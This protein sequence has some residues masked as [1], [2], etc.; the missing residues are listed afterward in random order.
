MI[1]KNVPGYH[2][3]ASNTTVVDLVRLIT[4]N[5][6]L[7]TLFVLISLLAV[8]APAGRATAEEF[9][10][11]GAC[12]LLTVDHPHSSACD[13]EI[14]ANPLPDLIRPVAYVEDRD[15]EAIPR[16]ILL[17]NDPLPYPVAWQNHAWY[18]SD[19]PGVYPEND[20]TEARRIGRE[21]MYFI[22]QSVV[23]GG[24]VWHLIGPDRWMRAAFVSVL[25]IPARPAGVTGRWVAL[26]LRQQTLVAL[27]DD[28]PVF[29]TLISSGYY[30]QTTLGLYQVYARTLSMTMKGP[31]G[32]N[33]PIYIF[34]TRWVMFFN[35]HQGLHAM[36]YHNDFGT[37]Q[38]HGCVNVP[39]GDEEWLWTFFD[40]TARD[41]DP[42]G[43]GDFFVD[44]PDRAPWVYIYES[45]PLP[46]WNADSKQ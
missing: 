2:R 40:E 11:R 9:A 6:K 15:G 3:N 5:S 23:T 20:Y 27:D 37:K 31:P 25:Q 43:S 19:A 12:H 10:A 44:Y 1:L 24:E 22:Y 7:I 42:S 18:F 32:A 17:P 13:Q 38:S 29:A 35:K 33:P 8:A 34:P 36:P 30:L 28:Q 21:T 4:H 14:A 46:V 41:W 26:D 45:D 39:P 16:S